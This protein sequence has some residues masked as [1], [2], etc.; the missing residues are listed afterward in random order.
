MH[1][2]LEAPG[3]CASRAKP[4]ISRVPS[5]LIA[6]AS[7]SGRSKEIDAAQCTTA[8]TS[9][10]S[11]VARRRASSPRPGAV[12]V[13]GARRARGRGTAPG[14]ATASPGR[15]RGAPRRPRRRRRARGRARRGRRPRAAARGP[16]C[17]GSRWRRSGRPAAHAEP[18]RRLARPRARARAH[19][20]EAAVDVEDLAGD[21]ARDG[22]ESRKQHGAGDRRRVLDVPAAA[23]PGAATRRRGRSKPGMPRAA[24][25]SSGPARH[26][27]HAHAARAE[28]ARQVARRRP[29][30]PPWRR[31]SSR[32]PARRPARRSRARRRA[33][34]SAREQVRQ[35]RRRAP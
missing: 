21:R 15:R 26:E 8:P 18:P 6:R 33:A 14:R 27:V 12:E 11:A 30:A 16:P 23:A 20:V 29:R 2:A 5:T 25:V 34:P 31:P 9:S 17:R 35:R 13:A 4:I 7:S 19:R 28:V 10:A 3:A 1:E 22:R 24:S 32:R